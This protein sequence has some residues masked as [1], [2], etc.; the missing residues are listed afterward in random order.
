[1]LSKFRK[2]EMR[3][4]YS[5]KNRGLN[6]KRYLKNLCMSKWE[7]LSARASKDNSPRFLGYCI[8]KEHKLYLE[9]NLEIAVSCGN[10]NLAKKLFN[11]ILNWGN[12]FHGAY[13]DYSFIDHVISQGYN[14]WHKHIGIT[15]KI[16]KYPLS[17]FFRCRINE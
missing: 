9:Y 8:K 16:K 3:M 14:G 13:E 1:M 15:Q 17:A 7:I 12:L 4:M 6:P 11:L 10:I 5:L 2:Y